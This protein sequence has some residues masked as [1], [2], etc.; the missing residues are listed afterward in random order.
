MQ[1][2][3]ER[4][5]QYPADTLVRAYAAVL[6]FVKTPAVFGLALLIFFVFS[7]YQNGLDSA[8]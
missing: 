7:G 1:A 2:L 6:H 4:Y 5:A 8:A 3:F